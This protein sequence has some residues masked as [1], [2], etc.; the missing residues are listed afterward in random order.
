M[1]WAFAPPNPNELT[2]AM[3]SRRSIRERLEL[4]RHA[5]LELF[6]INVRIRRRK[7]ETGRNLA[8]LQNEH[9]F[10]KSGDARCSFQMAKVG[11][12]RA[13]RQ[14]RVGGSITRREL[15]REHA[16][17]SDRPPPS[18]CRGL[19]RSRSASGAIPASLQASCTSR[20]CASGLGSEMPLVCPS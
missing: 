6:K 14:R 16:L 19:R 18:Q 12:D 15:P 9:R 3:R 10:E 2:P 7:M 11:F 17:R 4:S 20:V 8:V 5:Q 13:N 1:T